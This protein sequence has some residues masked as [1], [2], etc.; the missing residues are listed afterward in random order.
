MSWLRKILEGVLPEEKLKL[1]PKGFQQ[2]GRIA[3]L[4]L[5]G[6][7]LDD[8]GLIA[9]KILETGQVDTVALKTGGIEGWKRKPSIRVIAG[10]PLTETVHREGGCVFKLDV[11]ET[12]FSKGNLSERQ[13]I[14]EL[15]GEGEVVADLFAGVGQFAIPI[16]KKGRAKL[17]YAI[18]KNPVAYRYLCEN[19]RINKVG[20]IVVPILGDCAQVAPEGVADRVILGIIHVGHLY[21][22]LASSVLKEEGG[23][24]HYHETVPAKLASTRPLKRVEE[25][26]GREIKKAEVRV[27]KKYSPRVLHVVV[28]AYVGRRLQK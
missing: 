5:P 26:V 7:L 27:V 15:V 2:I 19:V 4:S 17:V 20:H 10:K 13:R 3:I 14:A 21:L 12:M 24:I 25:G 28:D 9:R 18:E 23:V 11:A 22:P 1:L 6:E 8:A 16:A